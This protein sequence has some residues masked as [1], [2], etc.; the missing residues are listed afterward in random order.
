M[1][2]INYSFESQKVG[3]DSIYNARELGGY[4]L[5]DG[6]KIKKGLLLRGGA[7]AKASREDLATLSSKFHLAH[8]F[9]FRTRTEVF[10][11]PDRPVFGSDQIWLPAIDETSETM[12]DNTLPEEA[13]ADLVGWLARN[14]GNSMLQKAAKDIYTSMITNEYTQLQYTS[15]LQTI[16]RTES[17]GIY[18]HCSQGKDRTGLGAAFI[19]AA[20]GADRELILKDFLMSNEYYAD[21][22]ASSLEL[23]KTEPE[24]DVIRTFIGVNGKYFNDALDL[25]DRRYG[26]LIAYIQDQLLLSDQDIEILRQRYLE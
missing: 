23:V 25:I 5:P 15:F 20:L 10:L 19:L 8:I 24:K 2:E 16:V 4:L 18:W 14:A 12:A 21:V 26:S 3:L 6:K 17:G 9:D 7:L 1:S 13:Y 11:S 22:L